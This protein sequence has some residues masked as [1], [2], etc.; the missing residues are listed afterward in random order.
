MLRK[1]TILLLFTA[2]LP[3]TL[4]A[5]VATTDLAPG[6]MR[7]IHP[8]ALGL[9][10]AS[11][12]PDNPAALAWGKASLVGGGIIQGTYYDLQAT[13]SDDFDGEYVGFRFVG[14]FIS[15]AAETHSVTN[16]DTLN[17]IKDES[18]NIH[19]A[20][21]LGGV[22]ALG[23]AAEE[24]FNQGSDI[25]IERFTAG[26]SLA[27]NDMFFVGAAVVQEEGTFTTFDLEREGT[28]FGVA[29]RIDGDWQWYGAYDVIDL[30]DLTW[31]GTV[32]G[33]A[34][35]QD[36]TT[37]QVNI[38]NLLLGVGMFN[39]YPQGATD[40]VFGDFVEIG[41]APEDGLSITARS[42]TTKVTDQATGT[43]IEK[44]EMQSLTVAWLF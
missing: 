23:V 11:F 42:L 18:T 17:P 2:F 32:V 13:T 31:Q 21:N 43:D 27:L 4:L 10:G 22:L 1:I 15:V 40:D 30:D 19:A 14:D 41:W 39:V 5:Q 6:T 26:V 35:K 25:N 37:L 3:A 9:N 33:G 38:G 12:T 29:F 7:F 36:T 34:I 44:S 16:S 20:F 24:M 8:D 28:M